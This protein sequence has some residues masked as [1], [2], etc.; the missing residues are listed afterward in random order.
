MRRG[1][2]YSAP[3]AIAFRRQIAA[4]AARGGDHDAGMVKRFT[5]R[6]RSAPPHEFETSCADA[7]LLRARAAV[8][9][10]AA[11]LVPSL[12]S[13]ST[14]TM[15]QFWQ[16]AWAISTSSD[17][18][19]TI[20]RRFT[21]SHAASRSPSGAPRLRTAIRLHA[22]PLRC[23]ETAVSLLRLLIDLFEAAIGGATFRQT[24]IL[25]RRPS[26]PLPP[27]GR[28]MRPRSRSSAAA[29]RTPAVL[30]PGK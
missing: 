8:S 4:V 24:R 12:F 6:G 29:R 17:I 13:A 2:G 25:R 10:A 27:P 16:I 5:V 1:A 30:S 19:R 28:C 21:V 7:P 15:W 14:S 20:H 23:S 3:S 26:G 22:V 9:S 11:K 18:S